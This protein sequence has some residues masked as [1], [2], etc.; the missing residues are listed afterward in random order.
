LGSASHTAQYVF[1]GFHISQ[2]TAPFASALL[3]SSRT[4]WGPYLVVLYSEA[5]S[6]GRTTVDARF[7][8]LRR[9]TA[10]RVP[11]PMI[12]GWSPGSSQPWKPLE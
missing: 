1:D 10:P 7:A 4:Y 8:A 2:P 3:I 9:S 5:W 11:I 6:H 12:S